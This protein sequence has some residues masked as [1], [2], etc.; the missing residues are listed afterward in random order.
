MSPRAPTGLPKESRR[1]RRRSLN[2]FEKLRSLR[3]FQKRFLPFLETL[4]D[5]DVIREIGFNQERGTPITQNVLFGKNIASVATVQRR[6]RR[7]KRL[8]VVIENR[9]AHDKRNLEL[10]ISP[11]TRNIYRRKD[12]LLRSR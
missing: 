7:L 8:G 5:L 10:K 3:A 4:E 9:S 11:E 6:L 1:V 2:I 12:L